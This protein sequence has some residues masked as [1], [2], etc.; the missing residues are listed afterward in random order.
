[1]EI[2]RI[3]TETPR[4]QIT[5]QIRHHLPKS[6]GSEIHEPKGDELITA[7]YQTLNNKNRKVLEQLAMMMVRRQV[8]AE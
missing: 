8:G 6:D 7:L 3:T 5:K 2:P 1:M 4:H